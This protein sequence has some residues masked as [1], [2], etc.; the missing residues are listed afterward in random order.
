MNREPL[1]PVGE[2]QVAAYRR[3][4]AVVLRRVFDGDWIAR[5]AEGVERNIAE[6]GRH[7][8]VYTT[9][10]APGFFF[11][12]YCNWDRIPAYRAAAFDSPAAAVAARLMGSAKVNFFHE[13]VL[14]KEP[15][16]AEPTPWHHDQPYWTV[17]GDMVCSL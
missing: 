17:D 4:G 9:E 15:G 6:P 13:H 2:E 1:D 14:V 10:G 7:A 3:D 12:D 8:H 11:G 16:T 5:L